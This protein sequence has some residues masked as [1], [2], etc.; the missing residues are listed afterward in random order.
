MDKKSQTADP[1]HETYWATKTRQPEAEIRGAKRYLSLLQKL[2]GKD[3]FISY[4]RADGAGYALA[5][6]AQLS[7]RGFACVIDQWGMTIPGLR[8]PEKVHR[9]LRNCRALVIVGT[10]AS[11]AS[12]H[13][14]AEIEGFI[15]TLGMIIPIDLDGT[16]REARWWPMIEGLPITVDPGGS[17]AAS[18]GANI[19]ERLTNALTF[20]RRDQRLRRIASATALMLVLML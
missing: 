7:E 6:A 11:G 15:N 2:W 18:P 5:L 19:V 9:L 1:Q 12:P 3:V 17:G 13:V 8:T 20:H 14:T 4:S 10:R 16:I